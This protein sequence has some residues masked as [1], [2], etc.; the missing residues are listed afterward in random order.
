MFPARPGGNTRD[1]GFSNCRTCD[2]NSLCPSR[3][4][5]LWDRK[6]DH[7]RLAEYRVMVEGMD[8]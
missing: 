6:K 3:R 7:K 5:R 1:G 2:F 4:D 8:S